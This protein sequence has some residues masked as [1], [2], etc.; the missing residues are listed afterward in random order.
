MPNERTAL[1]LPRV[2]SQAYLDKVITLVRLARVLL[3]LLLAFFTVSFVI[4]LA[5]SETGAVEKV[6]LIGLIVG[7]VFVAAK[8]STMATTA[9]MWLQR[10]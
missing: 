9:Q 7:C 8:V 5:S 2:A 10:R 6:A 1:D 3:V 4:G